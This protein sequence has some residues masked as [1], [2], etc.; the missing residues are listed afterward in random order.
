MVQSMWENVIV[1]IA[2]GAVAI[3]IAAWGLDAINGWLQANLAENLAF[4]WVWKLDRAAVLS[5]CAFVAGAVALLGVVV[6]ARVTSTRFTA[7]LRDG[8]TRTGSRREG[9]VAR[10][11]VV[12]QVA[13][14]TVLMFF[15][16]MAGVVAY[17][18]AHLD[19]GY[20]TRRLLSAVVEL[21][22]ER[23]ASRAERWTFY[24]RL[25][26]D[27]AS[28]AAVEAPLL[29]AS[30]ASISDV[31]GG[32]E[33]G[34]SPRTIDAA[35]PRAYVQ[36]VSGPLATLGIACAPGAC[37]MRATTTAARRW[38]S[39]AARWPSDT[40]PGG[41]RSESAFASPPIPASRNHARSSAS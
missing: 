20:D 38:Q 21:P 26:A 5:G 4:W 6:S 10:A 33:L 7:V 31:A 19:V 41:I 30:L 29:R 15:G 40:G 2:G 28:S 14:V 16:T 9:R 8:G 37:S 3:A 1:C 18:I 35:S 23:Y 32:F 13:A 11:L 17:R 25:S 27:L 24:Q 12:A 36:A 22:E 39:S 34:T